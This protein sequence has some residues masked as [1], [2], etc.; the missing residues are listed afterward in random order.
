MC[1]GWKLTFAAGAPISLSQLL[2]LLSLTS[3]TG[4]DTA[5]PHDTTARDPDTATAPHPDVATP[6]P[7]DAATPQ[8]PDAAGL[9]TRSALT[10]T[11]DSVFLPAETE[12]S[13]EFPLLQFTEHPTSGLGCWSVHPCH[14][15]EAVSE[16]VAESGRGWLETWFMLSGNV[17][18]LR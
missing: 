13:A 16:L 14:V 15:A 4:S 9:P 5:S 6:P 12:R 1:L 8:P 17:V 11:D 18:D 2:P 10:I 3:A 7:P